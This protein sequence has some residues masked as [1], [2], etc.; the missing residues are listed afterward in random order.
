MSSD[1]WPFETYPPWAHGAGYLLS[2]DLARQIG[3]G[4]AALSLQGR[5]LHLED[6]STGVWVKYAKDRL[7]T[8]IQFVHDTRYEIRHFILQLH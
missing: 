1:D 8:E 2:V 3:C 5:I 6:V 4:A 7:Q